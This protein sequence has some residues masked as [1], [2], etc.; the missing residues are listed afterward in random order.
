MAFH[1]LTVSLF[2]HTNFYLREEAYLEEKDEKTLSSFSSSYL[3]TLI[4]SQEKT[5]VGQALVG[6]TMEK[7]HPP[8]F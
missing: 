4:L 1:P 6:A 7:K 3:L 8:V 2:S 5:F